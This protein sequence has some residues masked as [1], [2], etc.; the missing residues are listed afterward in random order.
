[1]VFPRPRIHGNER[2]MIKKKG[3]NNI[4]GNTN[5]TGNV[6]VRA[7]IWMKLIGVFLIPVGFIVLLGVISFK[8]ASDALISNYKNSTLSNLNNMAK[9]L[10]L[11]FGTVSD[12]ATLLNTNSTL[13]NYY[14]GNYKGNQIEE[15][16]KF[17]ELQE[18]AYANILSDNI[19]KN[20]YIFSQYGN[21]ILTKG[22]TNTLLYKD[23]AESEEGLYFQNSGVNKKWIGKH[24]YLDAALS[25]TDKDYSISLISYIFNNNSEKVGYILLDVSMDF[26]LNTLAESGLPKESKIAFLMKDGK[27]IRGNSS[28]EDNYFIGKEYFDSFLSKD[29]KESGYDEAVVDGIKHLFFYSYVDQCDGYLCVLLPQP[30]ITKQADSLKIITLIIVIIASMVAIVLGT[31]ISYGISNTIKKINSVLDRSASGDLTRHISIKRKDEFRLLGNGINQLISNLKELI[32]DMANVSKTVYASSCEVSESSSILLDSSQSINN[33]VD[34]VIQGVQSQ[35]E[36]MESSLV[37]MSELSRQ[38]E[39]LSESTDLIR[40]SADDTKNITKKGMA[41]IDELESK[42]KKSSA[43]V[44]S[45]IENIENLEQ[46]SK[47]I[48]EILQGINEISEQTNLLSL[49][50]SIEAARAGAEGRGFQVV[51]SEIRKLAERS[52]L[53]AER[54]GHIIK[55]IQNQTQIT[56][57]TARDAQEEEAL[58]E[59]TLKSAVSVFAEIDNNVERLTAN[60]SSIMSSINEIEN[61]K[62][63]TLAAIEEISAI[64]EQ[65]TAAMEQFRDMAMHQLKAVEALNKTVEELSHDSDL[66]EQKINI[67]KTNS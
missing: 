44:K 59:S 10:D 52:A 65:T 49:N 9:Y 67:F 53:E 33:V 66:L 18:Y 17:K 6:S 23:F 12:K 19:I 38:I 13:K 58:R 5:E 43:I 55:E 64:S 29:V 4:D 21:A 14:S 54:I 46:K 45:V 35:S 22:T 20:I 3:K 47:A 57:K 60:L 50:A 41:I 1:M 8:K 31:L 37:Q 28:S 32:N 11:G 62:E 56:V 63:D 48:S 40:K 7:K 24:P 39:K 36:G 26:V 51:A 15:M 25:I 16:K 61:A 27:E 42:T 30:Y 34:E 2:S